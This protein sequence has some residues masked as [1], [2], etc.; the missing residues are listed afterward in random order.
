MA[1]DNDSSSS[2]MSYSDM[3]NDDTFTMVEEEDQTSR[4]GEKSP[5]RSNKSDVDFGFDD[6][7]ALDFGSAAYSVPYMQ[8]GTDQPSVATSVTSVPSDQGRRPSS[9]LGGDDSSVA[10][11]SPSVDSYGFS[12]V[13]SVAGG[14]VNPPPPSI[15]QNRGTAT[16]TPYHKMAPPTSVIGGSLTSGTSNPYYESHDDDDDES[17]EMS[18]VTP[19]PST[20]G[21][22]NPFGKKT[23]NTESLL[24]DTVKI[25]F[26]PAPQRPKTTARQTSTTSYP[27]NPDDEF[28]VSVISSL[29]DDL[30]SVQNSS[31]VKYVPSPFAEAGTAPT[32]PLTPVF[33]DYQHKVLP[34]NAPMAPLPH[35]QKIDPSVPRPDSDEESGVPVNHH[36]EYPSQPF[37][38]GNGQ[39][40]FT[41]NL[42]SSSS[43]EVSTA[44]QSEQEYRDEF[45]EKNQKKLGQ[46][47]GP[48]S[49]SSSVAT[50]KLG[51]TRTNPFATSSDDAAKQ[52]PETALNLK[53]PQP[54]KNKK[55]CC[56][57]C[58]CIFIPL[59]LLILGGG[60]YYAYTKDFYGFD[61]F[62]L[63]ESKD[64]A[65][66]QTEGGNIL[67]NS[68]D[69]SNDD[70]QETDGGGIGFPNSP[71]SS[72]TTA[73]SVIME[74]PA[75]DGIDNGATNNSTNGDDILGNNSTNSN[76][77]AGDDSLIGII[78]TKQPHLTPVDTKAPTQS[79]ISESLPTAT[80]TIM[81]E[82]TAAPTTQ[83]ESEIIIQYRTTIQSF[84]STQQGIS[85]DT[86]QST[87][88]VNALDRL[89]ND[90]VAAK[91]QEVEPADPFYEDIYR[92]TQ[93]F[94]L[95]CLGVALEEPA[96]EDF[97]TQFEVTKSWTP[98]SDA[99][100][101]Y[102]LVFERLNAGETKSPDHCNWPG[103]ICSTGDSPEIVSITWNQK[104]LDGT[105]P[106]EISLLKALTSIDLANNY[107][108]GTVP[109]Q[110]YEIPNLQKLVLNHNYLEGLLPAP[111][112]LTRLTHLDMGQNLLS[113]NLQSLLSA[114]GLEYLN[115]NKNTLTGSIPETLELPSIA[116]LDLGHNMLSGPLPT[117]LAKQAMQV[118]HIH[119]EYNGFSGN[120]PVEYLWA[121]KFQLL[122]LKVN[123]N[124]L[125]GAVPSG[126]S[127]SMVEYT[128]QNN[129]FSQP[130]AQL[131]CELDQALGLGGSVIEF[132][133]DCSICQCTG[134]I[135]CSTCNGGFNA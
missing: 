68:Q 111:T 49:V 101:M 38:A 17:V 39:A 48:V 51:G 89:M 126:G 134:G 13:G 115:L 33:P 82:A 102:P 7:D 53:D 96:Q 119:L 123:N 124:Q 131:T 11:A 94:A 14:S 35:G 12:A 84:L 66:Q 109:S 97:F 133:A 113:G 52:D 91:F 56:R 8:G 99:A 9:L 107:I 116:Y 27:D 93:R 86:T 50:E 44:G 70:P 46:S 127:K 25:Q 21:R 62:G 43:D 29:Q 104:G 117:R 58:L 85:F 95:Y 65:Q 112:A 3:Y 100:P 26:V 63:Y 1:S 59:L 10:S 114:Q 57:K 72:S 32:S 75:D 77:T 81:A 76:S 106:S 30:S 71:T 47:D 129:Q 98:R 15:M 83:A 16:P 92:V 103:V 118:R 54:K 87:M 125:T 28:G 22:N 74:P 121:G 79:P 20:P 24:Q 132:E 18:L 61:F 45:L 120:L 90:V 88:T 42:T 4:I 37:G 55:S 31:S 36:S 73:P 135:F 34:T 80:P 78:G 69:V 6:E 5:S 60:G 130:L 110:L 108:H 19:E 67:E 23:K 128:L 40:V 64:A 122:T 105:I 2:P 41:Y